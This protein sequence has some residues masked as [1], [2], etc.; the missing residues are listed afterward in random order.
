MNEPN[1]L[2]TTR[3]EV[4]VQEKLHSV[5]YPKQSLRYMKDNYIVTLYIDPTKELLHTIV[6]SS[7]R[8]KHS[9]GSR[10]MNEVVTVFN[11]PAAPQRYSWNNG[12]VFW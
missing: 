5:F 2:S 12:I 6:V 4:E 7:G 11:R 3:G 10:D 1:R 9:T 8:L